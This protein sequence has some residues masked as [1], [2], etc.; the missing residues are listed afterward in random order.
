V[1]GGRR[2]LLVGATGVVGK[3][4][5]RQLAADAGVSRVIA[6]VR[7]PIPDAPAS[8][9]VDVQVVDFATI[10]SR[11]ELFA[12][13]QVVCALGTTIKVAGS[14]A[15]FRAVDYELPYRVATLARAQGARHY[16]LV[17]AL[18]AA[19]DSSV[20][21]NRVKGE[22]EAD[23]DA[24]GFRS[25][26]IARPS[27]LLGDRAEFRLGERL[28][29]PFGFLVP[30][31]WKPVHARQVAAALVKAAATDLAGRRVMENIELRQH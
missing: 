8:P 9:N 30:S 1:S 15:A 26:T 28:T 5:L 11:P 4:C 7:R 27:L 16:L 29:Q 13:D 21:Y 18:G 3:E 23:L 6:L 2:V 12:V 14:Q 10:E 24:L 22:L 20:F 19:K 17:S 31:K 25:L